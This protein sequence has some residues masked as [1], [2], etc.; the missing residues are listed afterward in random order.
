MLPTFSSQD[1][2][3]QASW[4]EEGGKIVYTPLTGLQMIIYYL[5]I[6]YSLLGL[7]LVSSLF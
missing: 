4:K 5:A 3:Y 6:P 2:I 7:T 1:F